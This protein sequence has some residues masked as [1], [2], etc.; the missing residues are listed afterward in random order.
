MS[1]FCY[2][3]TYRF[4]QLVKNLEYYNWAQF[5]PYSHMIFLE[6]GKWYQVWS[7]PTTHHEKFENFVHLIFL[8]TLWCIIGNVSPIS[9]MRRLRLIVQVTDQIGGDK[10]ASPE[11][12][13]AALS[14]RRRWNALWAPLYSIW[15]NAP[16]NNKGVIAVN[17]GSR[18]VKC[19]C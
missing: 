14:P 12:H 7:I 1:S 8:I 6:Q 5:L 13:D 11:C 16:E 15:R 10:P 9:L 18:T 17:R 4:T 19:I 3:I 2:I